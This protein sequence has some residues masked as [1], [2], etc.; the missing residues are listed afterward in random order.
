MLVLVPGC[1]CWCWDVSAMLEYQCYDRVLVTV[2]M[3]LRCY[4][5]L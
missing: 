5:C 1:H 3:L 4:W 2:S